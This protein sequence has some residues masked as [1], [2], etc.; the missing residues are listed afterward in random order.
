[1]DL[2][3]SRGVA[4][5]IC[6]TSYPPFG[7]HELQRI[8]VKTFLTAGVPV[9]ISTDDPLLFGVGLS[10]QYEICRTALG[11]TD[12]D[13]A[14]LAASGIQAS[15]APSEVKTRLLAE[16]ATWLANGSQ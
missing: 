11:L 13:L 5:E 10:G 1:M 14:S 16:V 6:P 8:P 2:L 12:E 9:A 15:A 4:L 7:V 3:A